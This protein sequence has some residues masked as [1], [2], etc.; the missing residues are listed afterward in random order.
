MKNEESRFE[1]IDELKWLSSFFI[2][3]LL[4]FYFI[5]IDSL[6]PVN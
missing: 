5:S 1:F 6:L 2:S 3:A 4:V